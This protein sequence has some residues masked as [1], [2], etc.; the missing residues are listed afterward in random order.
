[1]DPLTI[2][3][4]AAWIVVTLLAAAFLGTEFILHEIVALVRH[5]RNQERD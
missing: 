3:V 4:S 5:R 1:M 2:H